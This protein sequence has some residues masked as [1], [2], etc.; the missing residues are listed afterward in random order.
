MPWQLVKF[1]TYFPIKA[2]VGIILSGDWMEPMD[3]FSPSD[4]R[5]SDRAMQF[6][7]G[8]FANPIFRDGDYPQVMRDKIGDKTMG[9]AFAI[10][11]LPI[12]SADEKSII[13]GKHACQVLTARLRYF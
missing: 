8:W 3:E 5:A 6:N 10:S 12:L 4:W 7:I 1:S 2:E 9:T 11:R 13:K